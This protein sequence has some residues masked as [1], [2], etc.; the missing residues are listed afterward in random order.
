MGIR[1]YHAVIELAEPAP[2]RLWDHGLTV[3]MNTADATAAAGD[4]DNL[5]REIERILARPPGG[6][7]HGFVFIAV[8]F[9]S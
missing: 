6:I 8:L 1:H 3:K 2:A 5:T 7:I 9:A 4:E